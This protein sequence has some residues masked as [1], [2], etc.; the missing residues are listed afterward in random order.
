M[1]AI[2]T[3]TFTV[4]I[5][6]HSCLTARILSHDAQL[7]KTPIQMVMCMVNAMLPLLSRW[8]HL[9]LG[10]WAN[11]N[12]RLLRLLIT[13]DQ[14]ARESLTRPGLSSVTFLYPRKRLKIYSST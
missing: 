11:L 10:A 14:P 6:H 12:L 1:T 8:V 9:G 7:L 3:T 5:P 13:G 4:S 2:Q